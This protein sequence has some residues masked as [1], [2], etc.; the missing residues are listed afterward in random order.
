[1][2]I[3]FSMS[4]GIFIGLTL[5]YRKRPKKRIVLSDGAKRVLRDLWYGTGGR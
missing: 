5:Y 1:M 4:A 3:I 2:G